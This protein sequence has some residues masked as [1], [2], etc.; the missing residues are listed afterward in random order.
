MIELYYFIPIAVCFLFM[1]FVVGSI[2]S[3]EKKK[4]E[5]FDARCDKRDS[6]KKMKEYKKKYEST[7]E[8]VKVLRK[9]NNSLRNIV[10]SLSDELEEEYDIYFKYVPHVGIEDVYKERKE[11]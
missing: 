6:D 2:Y 8:A 5:L 9:S 10:E 7:E 3:T 4:Q 11:K 1:G